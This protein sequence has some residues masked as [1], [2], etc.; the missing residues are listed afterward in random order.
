MGMKRSRSNGLLSISTTLANGEG[1][2]KMAVGSPLKAVMNHDEE[3]ERESKR[4]K[5][6]ATTM[7]P[8]NTLPPLARDVPSPQPNTFPLSYASPLPSGRLDSQSMRRV[9]SAGGEA[10]ERRS[11]ER[12]LPGRLRDYEMKVQV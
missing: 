10:T 3:R 9:V 1:S 5:L 2:G 6:R 4:S 11:R 7:S 12:T 8:P